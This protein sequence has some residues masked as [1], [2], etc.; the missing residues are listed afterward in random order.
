MSAGVAA[1]LV[2]S[3][4]SDES[5]PPVQGVDWWNGPFAAP[6]SPTQATEYVDGETIEEG[7][8]GLPTQL[9]SVGF[10][11]FDGL[12]GDEAILQHACGAGK[13]VLT[14]W[15]GSD[16][17]PVLLGEVDPPDDVTDVRD[18]DNGRCQG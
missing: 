16:E 14:V 4:C 6:C 17:G 10:A 7:E 11:E 3:G 5:S 15:T 13:G 2:L 1:A 8:N 12:A 18:W 9:V